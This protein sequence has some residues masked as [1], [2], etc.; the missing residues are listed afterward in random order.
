[1]VFVDDAYRAPEELIYGAESPFI[2]RERE[3]TGGGYRIVKMPHTS[4]GLTQRLA[5]LGWSFAMTDAGPF[6]WGVGTR[7]DQVSPS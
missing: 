5:G 3:R 6:F 4:A 2:L 1:V 7:A